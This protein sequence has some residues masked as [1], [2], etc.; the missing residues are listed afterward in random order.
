MKKNEP[1]IECAKVIFHGR[2]NY[3]FLNFWP[4]LKKQPYIFA[5][6][7]KIYDFSRKIG[8]FS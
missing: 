6:F 5:F 2:E 4:N 8:K 3:Q 7:R 1:K